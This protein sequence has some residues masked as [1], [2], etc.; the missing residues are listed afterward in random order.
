M[1]KK[2]QDNLFLAVT[3]KSYLKG[4]PDQSFSKTRP[5]LGGTA[6]HFIDINLVENKIYIHIFV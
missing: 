5:T 6:G 4:S 1:V 2:G 3:Y